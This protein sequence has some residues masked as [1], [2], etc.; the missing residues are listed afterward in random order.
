MKP[1]R[2][3]VLIIDK[4]GEI[5]SL[6]VGTLKEHSNVIYVGA[7]GLRFKKIP[8]IPNT[9]Y[10]HIL[11]VYST[12]VER[13]GIISQCLKKAQEDLAKL[14][15]IFQREHIDNTL[16]ESVIDT[17]KNTSVVI[18]GD[19]FDAILRRIKSLG[20]IQISESGVQKIFPVFS[21]DIKREI[22]RITFEPTTAK[23]FFIFPKHPPTELTL[24]R[25]I[26][27]VD[28]LVR[29]D[30]TTA[31]EQEIISP[32]LSFKQQGE[33]V[34]A[35]KYP[36]LLD[37]KKAYEDTSID[38]YIP[39]VIPK[40]KNKSSYTF[41]IISFVIVLLLL[42]IVTMTIFGF[43]GKSLL[44]DAKNQINKGEIETAKK[45]V[46]YAHLF[47]VISQD[48][49]K[50]VNAQA[51]LIG[52]NDIVSSSLKS[53]DMGEELSRGLISL[54]DA[55]K[56]FGSIING[57]SNNP[58]EEID[59]NTHLIKS[60]LGI[61][62]KLKAEGLAIDSFGKTIELLDNTIDIFPAILG[63]DKKRV[64]L[65]L[66]QN[67][68]ELR[69][70]GG[71]IGSYGLLTVHNGKIEDFSLH[72]VY[73]ADGQL[74]GHIEPPF[75]IRRYLPSP[76]WYLRDSNFDVDFSRG[77]STSAYFLKQETGEMVDGVIGVDITFVQNILKAIGPIY[78]S[79]YDETVSAD[80]LYMLTQ[81]HVE[82]DFFPG[83][84]QKKDFLRS[85]FSSLKQN[86]AEKKQ[87]SYVK[88]SK[89][90][91][92]SL[93]EK[94]ILFSFAEPRTQS[95]FSVNGVSSA[96][97]D[98]R[99]DNKT[100]I[101]DFLGISEANLGSNKANFFIKRSIIQEATIQE[102]SVSSQVTLEYKNE[103][104]S[105]PGGDYKNYL[106]IL[107]PLGATLSF[108]TIDGEEQKITSAITDPLV[109]EAKNFTAP[110]GLEIEQEREAGKTLFGF[111]LIVPAGGTKKVTLAYTFSSNG[112]NQSA[113]SYDHK[114][115]KQPGTLHDPFSFI[116]S[117]PLDFKVLQAPSDV[118]KQEGRVTW[119]G[120]LS[121]DKNLIINFS[122]R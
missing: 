28:P 75:P 119:T 16:I 71:F 51:S 95:L 87:I 109:Y 110:L 8:Q 4:K 76:H 6:L 31:K 105:W 1:V 97:W 68:M 64:Y 85:L 34:L 86:I 60:A 65:V 18:Y 43:L 90:M 50:G 33:Y 38:A 57:K 10:T 35:A 24:A 55:G 32:H 14:I 5:A 98:Q 113:F 67:N 21:E 54:F 15:F 26:H 39:R 92:D 81:S 69:P 66:F 19:I 106:R 63:V 80:N 53:I 117:F 72:D 47:F 25:L 7:G 88:L 103:S 115:F 107:V 56:S 61:F 122:K 74:K 77:A 96:V 23:L 20:Q 40:E 62:Q 89:S 121:T 73:E 101:N 94:H 93:F 79:D 27:K 17:Y 70:G 52:K 104:T 44:I 111:F 29:I 9:T 108:V 49:A 120:D 2:H 48:A 102:A 46:Y 91:E 58:K 11:V 13:L 83:S 12:Q 84:T 59:Q 36:Q 30:F 45:R 41:A 99:A 82:K 37:I 22:L 78:V 116:L 100:K 3:T 118:K 42:P 114:I 112:L